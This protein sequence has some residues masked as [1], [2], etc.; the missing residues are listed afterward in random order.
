MADLSSETDGSYEY[1]GSDYSY[2]DSETC[3]SEDGLFEDDEEYFHC[4]ESTFA[5]DDVFGPSIGTSQF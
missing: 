2:S 5:G 4:P 1:S 3:D